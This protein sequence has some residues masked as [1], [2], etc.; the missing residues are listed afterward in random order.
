[1]LID[2]TDDLAAF[3]QRLKS[4]PY[5]TVDTEFIRERTYWP[6]LCLVQLAGPDEA[7]CIDPL[8]EGID[9]TPLFDLMADSSI[10]K[11]FHAARQD[12]EIFLHLNDSLPTPLFDTQ[13]AAMVCGFG[14]SVGYQTLVSRLTN[15]KID[16]TMRF[17]D[18]ARRP[19]SEKQLAYALSDVTHLRVIYEKLQG[20]LKANGRES[21]LTE[22]MKMLTS[23]ETYRIEPQDAWRK[24][25]SRSKNKRFLAILQSLAEW[26]EE[27]AKRTDQP[28]RR[29]IR[30]ETLLEIAA[31]RPKTPEELAK[32]R[33]LS[34]SMAFGK[35]GTAIIKAVKKGIDC[36]KDDWP[37]Y[38]SKPSRPPGLGAVEDMLRLLLK[39]TCDGHD[40]AQ[41]LVASA[42]NIEAIAADD[43]A[44]VPAMKGWRYELFGKD[45]LRLKHGEICLCINPETNSYCIKE[46]PQDND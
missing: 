5:V 32:T 29:V 23:P 28:R 43:N 30:D 6:Q 14:D 4:A 15:Q 9:L 11:V 34:D 37:S 45:A 10:L 3:C 46:T 27:Q 7:Y 22:E 17:S 35:L 18:W 38:P 44:D 2:R 41:K 12:L 8:A 20:M 13:I 26:R 42:D 1:M 25:K 40:V 16:K 36:P 19:L 39:I 21:W 33:N 24:I 31:S